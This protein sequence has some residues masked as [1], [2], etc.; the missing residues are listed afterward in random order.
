VPD[1]E[2]AGQRRWN[3]FPEEEPDVRASPGAGA[4]EGGWK[5]QP[6]TRFEKRGRIFLPSGLVEINGKEETRFVP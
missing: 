1:T 5:V 6:T 4:L 2:P 3:G